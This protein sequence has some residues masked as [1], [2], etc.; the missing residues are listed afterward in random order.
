M[1]G[2]LEGE[3]SSRCRR[4]WSLALFSLT[5]RGRKPHLRPD[6]SVIGTEHADAVARGTICHTLDFT[7]CLCKFRFTPSLGIDLKVPVIPDDYYVVIVGWVGKGNVRW[8]RGDSN[9]VETEIS[10]S[11]LAK[12]SVLTGICTRTCLVRHSWFS[13]APISR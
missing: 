7:E 4:N 13:P 5:T 8:G 1:L 2:V 12:Q 11:P 3:T 10:G 9:G 6:I